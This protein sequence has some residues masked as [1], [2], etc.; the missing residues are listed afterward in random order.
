MLEAPCSQFNPVS[1]DAHTEWATLRATDW[2]SVKRFSTGRFLAPGLGFATSTPLAS[3]ICMNTS[4]VS[5]A[6]V[7]SFIEGIAAIC[8]HSPPCCRF[9]SRYR[10]DS[11][12]SATPAH[13]LKWLANSWRCSAS[14]PL[15]R[16]RTDDLDRMPAKKSRPARLMVTAYGD[17]EIVVPKI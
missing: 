1:V 9:Q 10:N 4:D 16:R 11:R 12:A 15:L 5:N 13:P 8:N 3:Q 14:V 6:H 17:L 7:D 2:C